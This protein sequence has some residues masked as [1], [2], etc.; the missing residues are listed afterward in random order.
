MTTGLYVFCRRFLAGFTLIQMCL[1]PEHD[2]KII[3]L[4]AWLVY[5][6]KSKIATQK[7]K[8]PETNKDIIWEP[9]RF[10][11]HGKYDLNVNLA[12]E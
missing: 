9:F 2:H 1:H 3:K 8:K 7:G 6:V 10:L 5:N 11:T 4:Q 12:F